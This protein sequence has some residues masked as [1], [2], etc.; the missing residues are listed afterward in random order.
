MTTTTSCHPAIRLCYRRLSLH[1][2]S[3]LRHVAC[4]SASF[5][6]VVDR[7]LPQSTS[8]VNLLVWRQSRRAEPEARRRRSRP[9]LDA[10]PAPDDVPEAT[11]PGCT[12]SN[13]TRPPAPPSERPS[14]RPARTASGTTG[15]ARAG[16]CVG[17]MREERANGPVAARHI[18]LTAQPVLRAAPARRCRTRRPPPSAR[19]SPP[20]AAWMGRRG[21]NSSAAICLASASSQRFQRFRMCSRISI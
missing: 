19:R 13:R 8:L 10:A 14:A 16:G 17:A 2:P 18:E 4:G 1:P 11:R 12:T 7:A 20:A 6:E 15:A 9:G 21:R 5:R 3:A